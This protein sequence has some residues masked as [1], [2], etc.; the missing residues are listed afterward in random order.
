VFEDNND[1]VSFHGGFIWNSPDKRYNWTTAWITGPEQPDNNRD[2]RSLMSTYLTAKFGPGDAWLVSAGG[3]LGYESNAAVD[4][5]TGR[6][7]DAK[8]YGATINLFYDVDPKLRIG[9]R[10]E[11]FR[12]EEGTRTAQL[13]RPGFAASFVDLTT[14][15]TY[16]PYRNVSIRPELRIDW[17]PDARPYNDQTSR[18][19]FVPAIDLIVRF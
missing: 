6:K 14:G 7:E 1:M 4:R 5:E 2:Y 17:S 8:W 12:D 19:Q 3:H 18:F 9:A 15:V 10:A 16:K 13:G 11:W